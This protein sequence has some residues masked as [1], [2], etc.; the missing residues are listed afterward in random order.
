MAIQSQIESL[1]GLHD[2]RVMS[3]AWNAED[4]TFSLVV[5]DINANTSGLP[6]Y[7]GRSM[8][9]LVFSGVTLLQ[10]EADLALDGLMIFEWIIA[11]KEPEG[12]CSS[13]SLSPGGRLA[14]E[15]RHIDIRPA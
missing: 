3:L 14:I 6:E 9:T 4:R 12:F 11:R 2:A 10:A 7:P 15:C 13:I 1:G 8:A 5:D